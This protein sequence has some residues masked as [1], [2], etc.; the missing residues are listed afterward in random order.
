MKTTMKPE[1]LQPLLSTMIRALTVANAAN[2]KTMLGS[3]GY[4]DSDTGLRLASTT[5]ILSGIALAAT[6]VELTG[7]PADA[8]AKVALQF[9]DTIGLQKVTE[10]EAKV[11]PPA[12]PPNPPTNPNPH[13]N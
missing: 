13:L 5:G 3:E 8:V 11:T 10:V 2:T 1:S 12:D 9:A 6:L 4:T 7:L